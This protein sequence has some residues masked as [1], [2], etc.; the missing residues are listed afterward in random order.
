[1]FGGFFGRSPEAVRH[2]RAS[3]RLVLFHVDDLRCA[4]DV[5]V[6][7]EVLPAL[8]LRPAR[9][10]VPFVAGM[11]DLRGAP[12]PVIDLRVRFGRAGAL[13]QTSDQLVIVEADGIPVALWTSGV[14]AVASGEHVAWAEARPLFVGDR[15]VVGVA[16]LEDGLVALHD[17]DGFITAS[18]A[19][20]LLGV[21]A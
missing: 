14:D 21:E 5:E 2:R 13:M 11:L 3:Q 1:M 17:V 18:E 10:G 4:I 16:I 15:S 6:V 7:R 19:E 20:A 8:A 12:V 9:V